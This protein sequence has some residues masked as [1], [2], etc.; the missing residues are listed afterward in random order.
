V[1]GL[2]IL[3][4]FKVYL[5]LFTPNAVVSLANYIWATIAYGGQPSIE[6]FC[7]TLNLSIESNPI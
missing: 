5:H 2:R 1:T 6:V 3:D 4:H 7:N